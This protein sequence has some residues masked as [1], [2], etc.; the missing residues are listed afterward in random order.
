MQLMRTPSC[1]PDVLSLLY[2]FHN[3]SEKA[4]ALFADNIKLF[5]IQ[6]VKEFPFKWF[7]FFYRTGK[8][9]QSITDSINRLILEEKVNLTNTEYLIWTSL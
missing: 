1:R 6:L 5:D 2:A 8:E 9:N 4:S 3:I 7:Y